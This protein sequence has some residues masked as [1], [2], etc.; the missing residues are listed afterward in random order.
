VAVW[1]AKD[2]PGKEPKDWKVSQYSTIGAAEPF[3]HQLIS[4][5]P[6]IVDFGKIIEP[7]RAK[8]KEAIGIVALEGLMPASNALRKIRSAPADLPEMD[9]R[10]LFDDFGRTLWV[11]YKGL[12][13]LAVEQIGFDIGFLFQN[14]GNF[15]KGIDQ[16]QAAHP[17]PEVPNAFGEYL[18]QQRE[19]WQNR[20][21]AW[22]NECLEHPGLGGCDKFAVLYNTSQA[23]LLF[24]AAWNAIVVILAALLQA[25]M[26]PGW[27]LV[28][29]PEA[30]RKSAVPDRF[31]FER[32]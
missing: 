32:I 4:E 13:P 25:K 12:L 1:R 19:G 23:E 24:E 6:R 30:E 14:D 16:F 17:E 10:Q 18:R 20:F 3:V 11:A 31:V 21:S 9:R 5:M 27:R 8:V 29:I 2:V 28:E 22:R 15:R 26:W 7:Q